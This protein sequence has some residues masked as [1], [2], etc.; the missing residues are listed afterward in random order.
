MITLRLYYII[1]AAICQGF[2]MRF[3]CLSDFCGFFR[4]SFQQSINTVFLAQVSL[5]KLV[6]NV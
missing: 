2:S 5:L 3:V 4:I 1:K 6:R